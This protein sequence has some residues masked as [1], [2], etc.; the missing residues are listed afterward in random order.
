MSRDIY[1]ISKE[2]EEIEKTS[3][4]LT[5]YEYNAEVFGALG[6]LVGGIGKAIG[7]TAD[8]LTLKPVKSFTKAVVGDENPLTTNAK[9]AKTA[10]GWVD[11]AFTRGKK[12][13]RKLEEARNN[14]K[15]LTEQQNEAYNNLNKQRDDLVNNH[16]TN[17]SKQRENAT[18]E[19]NT[20]I[21]VLDNDIRK[22]KEAGHETRAAE[23]ESQRAKIKA[24]HDSAMKVIDEA[25]RN[26]KSTID[27]DYN[28]AN[29][30]I[31]DNYG[32]AIKNN[33]IVARRM[34]FSKHKLEYLGGATV[35][36]L[37]G[38]GYMNKK[39]H[40]KYNKM[41]NDDFEL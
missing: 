20:R 35:A 15:N 7:W 25:D 18:T 16:N 30:I 29:K 27:A 41:Y 13:S 37:A 12:A 38:M 14:V 40:Q 24:D 32:K 26:G 19:Y 23:L 10:W 39:H 1:I 8:N 34:H 28:N 21:G 6:K 5:N 11:A 17:I 4:Q 9:D 36:G 33:K 22:A 3:R 2:S 31:N